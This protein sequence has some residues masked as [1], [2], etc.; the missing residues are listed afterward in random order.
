MEEVGREVDEVPKNN[1]A[2]FEIVLKLWLWLVLAR[3]IVM[4]HVSPN[5]PATDRGQLNTGRAGRRGG[6][7]K[8]R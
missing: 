5:M 1:A 7:K 2:H 6:S 4:P 8:E 3:G